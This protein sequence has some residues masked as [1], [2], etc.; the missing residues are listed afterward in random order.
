L[1]VN[2]PETHIAI[3]APESTLG[4]KRAPENYREF[5]Y[6]W[7]RLNNTSFPP[8]ITDLF[9]IR[10]DE[11]PLF[12][13]CS[14]R[15]PPA[16]SCAIGAALLQSSGS[17]KF[18]TAVG[19]GCAM[20]FAA[21]LCGCAVGPDYRAPELPAIDEWHTPPA[22]LA[23]PA[24]ADDDAT[25]GAWWTVLN[26]P[27]LNELIDTA[28]KESKTVEQTLAR[29]RESR[30][31]RNIS[32]A[33][34][35]PSIG[36]SGSARETHRSR[37]GDDLLGGDAGLSIS[38]E[39]Y[40]AGIDASWELDLFGR[41]R[42]SL[43]AS[44]ASLQAT[45]ADLRDVLIT[46]LGD[47]ALNYVNVRTTQS[48]LAFAERNLE[49]QRELVDITQW[50]AEA[51]L[52]T[53]LDVEQARASYAQ[54]L[55][56]LPSLQT[57]LEAAMNRLA[58]LTGREPGALHEK[59]AERQPIPTAPRDVVTSVPA[60]VLRRRPDLRSAE[61]R[62]AAQTAQVGVATAALYPSL[63]LSGS[64]SLSS[65]V[66]SDLFSSGTETT[67]YGLSLN[68]PIFRAGA[69]RQQVVAQN[70]LV[71]QALAS[72]EATVLSI[73]E[74]VENALTQWANEQRRY[75]ALV[76]AVEAARLARELAVIQYNS[77][78]VDFQTVVNADR[79]LSSTEDSLAVSS[80]ELTSN[81]IRL[82]KAFGGGWSVFPASTTAAAG[83]P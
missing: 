60:E 4:Y 11:M 27:T 79:Q 66:A 42:R 8:E 12:D 36:A 62:L 78:L 16:V 70:A 41:N 76:Q 17:F 75:E 18:R 5:R 43:E 40:N 2:P 59:L 67:G 68:I 52:A 82:Y 24:A 73:L 63:S 48:R 7:L 46:L 34:L 22:P 69:L 83:T 51:G 49:L 10:S 32:A 47:V 6:I 74:E 72:Y 54:T 53:V 35:F 80:G 77:G 45:E 61:R 30:A 13:D 37:D 65:A 28:V 15:I 23:K 55:A 29:V 9:I 58:V 31:R 25:L 19:R 81:L 44:T 56:Q 33:S 50:R 64:F 20:L 38:G 71:D 14:L 26:D 21:A 57:A 3:G 1:C 39:S